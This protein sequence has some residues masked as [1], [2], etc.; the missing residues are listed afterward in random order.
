MALRIPGDKSVEEDETYYI[1]TVSHNWVFG[2]GLKTSLGVTRGWRGD[3]SSLLEAI[4]AIGERY[5]IA[6]P[7]I[8]TES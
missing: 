3:D 7:A 2:P 5:E 8:K 6:Q 1:E 4:T